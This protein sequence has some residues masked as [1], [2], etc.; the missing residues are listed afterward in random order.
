MAKCTLYHCKSGKPGLW[1]PVILLWPRTITGP[2][3]PANVNVIS[4]R[5]CDD[6][7]KKAHP[8][9]F[10]RTMGEW[11]RIKKYFKDQ[12]KAEPTLYRAKMSFMVPETTSLIRGGVA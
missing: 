7:V 11:E 6:C 3:Q 2:V 5:I 4:H 1:E 12:Q 8:L 9:D 10:I